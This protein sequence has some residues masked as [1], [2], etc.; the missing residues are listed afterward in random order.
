MKNFQLIRNLVIGALLM[1]FCQ[2]QAQTLQKI[3]E[4]DTL[5]SKPESALYDAATKLIYVSNIHGEYC[6]KDGNGFISKIDLNG[7]I[8]DLKL[9]DGLDSPQGLA[10]FGQTLYVA[11]VDQIIQIDVPSGRKTAYSVDGAQFLN[12]VT[13]DSHG[14]VLFTDCRTN[15]V[16]MLS[17]G[18]LSVW[19]SDSL[20]K[21][22]N[23]VLWSGNDL[24]LTNM[25]N[26]LIYRIDGQ[27]KHMHEFSTGIVNGDGISSDGEDG[28]F[29]SGAWQGEI[30]HLDSQ[31]NKQLVLDLGPQN[32]IAADISYI[33]EKRLL[34]VPTLYKT[35]QAYIWTPKGD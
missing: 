20:L 24:L 28:Y 19:L 1:V 14:N 30:F 15:K 11:D 13:T 10:L 18:N 8:T 21:S 29:V 26:G 25:A 22:P 31:G 23:G 33:P 17:E 9:I 6:T 32:V 16:H 7:H 12:D 2:I 35:L 5:L 34:L 27:T 3:W 4:T